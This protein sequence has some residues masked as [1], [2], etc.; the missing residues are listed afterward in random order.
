[1]QKVTIVGL[2]LIGA[3][4]GLGLQKWA[5]EDGQRNSVL[6]ISGFDVAIEHQNYAKKI[7]AVNRTEWNL[8]D[9]VEGSDVIIVATPVNAIRE[10]FE[11]IAD[12]APQ[13]TIVTD[14][15]S[16]K[17]QV[18]EW[19]DQLLPKSMNFIG[20]H[21]MAGKAVS[22][23]GAEANL[24]KGAVWCVSPSVN[25]S[26]ESVQ[27]VLGIVSALDAE[28]RFIDPHE[29]DGFVGAVSHLPFMLSIALTR[30]VAMDNSWKELCQL[31]SSG[32][33]DMSRLAGGDPKMH[34][35]ICATNGDNIV[36][37]I[38][39]AVDQLTVMRELIQNGSDEAMEELLQEMD[40]AQHARAQWI[41]SARD[42]RMM[43]E[44]ESEVSNTSVGEQMQQ[45]L[46]GSLFR[47]RPKVG[48]EQDGKN[49]RS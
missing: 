16:T 11:I 22:I 20:G 26:D 36:R 42:G 49:G 35:D 46:F 2:G 34:R 32:F 43:D 18:M 6:E 31:S 8:G 10:V 12:R 28:P 14:T 4:I 1:M 24:F 33:R 5:T 21:P 37:W 9:A 47:R 44:P 27:T 39:S 41:T 38:D 13:D 23:E 15:G 45:M 40:G 25:A 17:A 7:K 29:H 19:A 30:S 48:N 3:S